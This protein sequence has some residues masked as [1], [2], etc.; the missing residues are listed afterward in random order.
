MAKIIHGITVA[1]FFETYGP[2]LKL[3]LLPVIFRL[4][5]SDGRAA[6][7]D[8]V[9]QV[10]TYSVAVAILGGALFLAL[11]EQLIVLLTSAKYSS[12]APLMAYLLPVIFCSSA[13]AHHALLI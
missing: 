1:H 6:T 8:F 5:E 7:S 2:R 10:F 9:S 13:G 4:W 3:A 11:S 12:S